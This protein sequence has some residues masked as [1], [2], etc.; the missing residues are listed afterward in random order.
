M[1]RTAYGRQALV[2]AIVAALFITSTVAARAVEGTRFRP[3]VHGRAVVV[4]ASPLASAVGI[5]VLE[6][7]GNAVDAAV[8]TLFAV[9]VVRPEMCGIGGGGFLVHRRANGAAAALD[10]RETA[11]ATHVHGS[12]VTLAGP[13]FANATGHNRVGVPGVV[14]GMDAALRRL[15]TMRLEDVLGPAIQLAEGGFAV[16]EDLSLGMVQHARRLRLYPHAASQY[17]LGGVL[18]YPP[19]ARLRLPA[20]ASDLR[21]IAEGG[22]RA[23]Y[24][25]RIARDIVVDMAAS[26]ESSYEGDAGQL[27]LADLA[28]Y[29]AVWREPLVG[30]YRGREVIAMPPPT[31]GGLAVIEMLNLL[32][33]FPLTGPGWDASSANHLHVLAEAQKIAWAD[34]NAFVGDPDFVDVP[35]DAMVSKAYAAH[36]RQEIDLEVAGS[37]A[38]GARSWDMDS[39]GA[40][41]K[42]PARDGANAEDSAPGH[43][44]HISVIDG[45]GDAV[46]VTCSIEKPFGSA[47][48]APGTGFLLNGQLGDFDTGDP[49]HPNAPVGGKRPRS[50]MSPII[51][52]EDGSPVVVA[53]AAGGASIPM[54]VLETVVNVVDFGMDIAQAVDAERVDARG[55]GAPDH[56]L[57][58]EWVRIPIDTQLELTRRGHTLGYAYCEANIASGGHLRCDDEYQTLGEVQAASENPFTG[59]RSGTSDPR[60]EYGAD[61]TDDLGKRRSVHGPR[62]RP[63]LIGR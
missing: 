20:Y 25:G 54:S 38:P 55:C 56:V 12:G 36:R 49:D 35:V 1:D 27:T 50:S 32:E 57:C 39:D 62:K 4:S 13:V 15:G 19:G 21:T 47:I 8:A 51:V 6:Q 14:A 52:V 11:P 17:L 59:R 34:R 48:V 2:V 10:F 37:Y 33:G 63:E 29:E 9:G 7:G 60:G 22:A 3:A 31:S 58:A 42:A 40:D 26:G 61:A 28:R 53:G 41:E 43:T 24:E 30:S 23:F 45:R 44:T 16:S 18:P 46:S 5:D